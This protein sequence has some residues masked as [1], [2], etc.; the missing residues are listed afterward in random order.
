VVR[1]ST[2]A[3]SLIRRGFFGPRVASPPPVVLKEVSP[4]LKGKDPTP[5]VGS[6]SVSPPSMPVDKQ[7][8]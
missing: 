8:V 6:S 2:P 3:K 7:G 4:M 5:E 1:P